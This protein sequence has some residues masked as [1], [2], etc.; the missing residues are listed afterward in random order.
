[1]C[2]WCVA[3][4]FANC[5]TL[6]WRRVSLSN[7][8]FTTLLPSPAP[9]GV[10]YPRV[11][12]ASKFLTTPLLQRGEVVGG[13]GLTQAPPPFLVP[14]RIRSGYC[15]VTA[16]ENRPEASVVGRAWPKNRSCRSARHCER[17]WGAR[18]G[19]RGDRVTDL[20]IN[21]GGRGEDRGA[22]SANMVSPVTVVSSGEPFNN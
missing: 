20:W 16:I 15:D 21:P 4:A 22:C 19:Y 18:S 6:G 2:V 3:C 1:M 5:A 7:S 11:A 12:L 9:G 14:V 17:D 13:T 8:P 10:S